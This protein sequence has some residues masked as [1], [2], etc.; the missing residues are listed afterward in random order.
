MLL[1]TSEGGDL[2]F[3]CGSDDHGPDDCHH[4][5]LDHLLERDPTLTQFLDLDNDL[6]A[7]RNAA[8]QEWT[9]TPAS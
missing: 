8:D 3:L 9:V 1:V 7:E 2:Q 4:V 6:F 5:G